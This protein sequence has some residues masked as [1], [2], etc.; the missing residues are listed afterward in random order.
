[1]SP[2]FIAL[3]IV[4]IISVVLFLVVYLVD[5]SYKKNK[6]LYQLK[7]QKSKRSESFAL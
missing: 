3:I 7:R 5:R 2:L 4:L 6:R 1:M